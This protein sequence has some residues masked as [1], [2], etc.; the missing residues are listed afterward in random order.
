[1]AWHR[2]AAVLFR[3]LVDVVA[4]LT[5]SRPAI[6]LQA[7]YDFASVGFYV[8]HDAISRI[9][10]YMRISPSFGKQGLHLMIP[11]SRFGAISR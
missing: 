6:A 11:A 9:R 5:A 7:R 2:D 4:A 8:R 10:T 3:M 1:M